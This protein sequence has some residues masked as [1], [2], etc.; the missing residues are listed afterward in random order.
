MHFL[1]LL[2]L[3]ITDL[4]NPGGERVVLREDKQQGVFLEGLSWTPVS[5]SE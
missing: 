1:A 2:H 3:Q 4:I 5:S